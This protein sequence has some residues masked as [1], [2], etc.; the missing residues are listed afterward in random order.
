[1][2]EFVKKICELADI[3]IPKEENI[4]E[5]CGNV[6]CD[7][8]EFIQTLNVS[9]FNSYL[10]FYSPLDEEWESIVEELS[11]VY[12]T[13]KNEELN[14]GGGFQYPY[15]LYPKEGGLLPWAQADNGTVFFWSTSLEKPWT[16]V[17]YDEMS[18]YYEYEMSTAEFIFKLISGE[19]TDSGLPDDLFING[20]EICLSE[21][22][23]EKDILKGKKVKCTFCNKGYFIP[24][25]TTYDKAHYFSCDICGKSI[26]VDRDDAVVE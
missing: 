22:Q 13:L 4:T 18:D 6:P 14:D 23:T 17:V 10:W 12:T 2:N 26:N 19:I 15:D 24:F 11:E 7:Y 1:M 3:N 5:A 25:N 20:I 9:G 16:I 8:L 21:Y